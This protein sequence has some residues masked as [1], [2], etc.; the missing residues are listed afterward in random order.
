MKSLG[1][2]GA[3]CGLG[4]KNRLTKA[5]M[6][7]SLGDG[8]GRPTARWRRLGATSLTGSRNM[9]RTRSRTDD[10]ESR[11]PAV[12]LSRHDSCVAGVIV[13]RHEQEP[14]DAATMASGESNAVGVVLAAARTLLG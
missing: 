5:A 8:S 7:D 14:P 3:S 6:S 11:I 13:N 10:S 4:L 9:I 12:V 2:V 1:L